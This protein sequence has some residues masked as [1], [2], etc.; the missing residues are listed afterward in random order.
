MRIRVNG[1]KLYFD[2]DGAGLVPAGPRMQERPTLLLIHGGPGLDHSSFKP[3][4]GRL[5]DLV[6]MVYLDLRGNGRSEAGSPAEWN[7]AQW[8]ADIREFC[9]ALDI[10]KPVVLGQSFG[11]EVAMTF[12]AA[13][14]QELSRLILL[15]ATAQLRM[16]RALPVFERLGGPEVRQLAERYWSRPTPKLHAEYHARCLSLY[17]TQKLHPDVL[18]RAIGREAVASY[19]NG[20]EGRTYN[21][22]PQLGR[23]SVPTLI[24]AGADDPI[25]T[26]EDAADIAGALPPGIATLLTLRGCR[27]GPVRE[28]PEFAL[29]VIRAFLQGQA[30]PCLQ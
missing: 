15:S 1:V 11:G 28:A 14:P 16:D 30:I 22:L 6:Q 26:L 5:T 9:R 17:T 18:S 4:F 13:Y 20:G 3:E 24:L 29:G 23:I 19:Y 27:H 7:L 25:T 21:L 10:E 2:V 8:A 12:A